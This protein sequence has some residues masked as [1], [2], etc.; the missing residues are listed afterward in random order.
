M[1]IASAGISLRY[2]LSLTPG[3]IAIA[4][5]L[6]GGW[7]TAGCAVYTMIL[8]IGIEHVTHNHK[9][10]DEIED[11][12]VPNII[13]SL[14][15]LFHTLSTFT[16]LYGVYAGVITG[17]FIWIAS[18]STGI[19]GGIEGINSAHELIHRKQIIARLGGIWNLLLVN[20]S[21]FYIEHIKGHH[22]YVGTSRDPATARY[23]ESFYHFFVRTVPAQFLSALNLEAHRLKK[24]HKSP[25]GIRN[26]VVSLFI[27]QIALCFLVYYFLGGLALLAYLHQSVIAFFLLEYVNY[28][29]H[30]G[31]QRKEGQK[32]NAT[33]SWQ[34]DLPI[35]RFALIELSRHSD[36]HITASKPYY[37]LI[38]YDDSPVL[39]AGYFGSFYW[40]LLPKLWF[41]KVNPVLDAYLKR[42]NQTMA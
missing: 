6:S 26:V 29:E 12:T 4:G 25:F 23:G 8:L 19:S 9:K 16:L 39:P 27:A 13:L 40:A 22:R 33:H 37:R 35:S 41:Q 28:I 42:Q 3:L 11:G 31:L 30:Y 38:T 32:V 34:C 36:H 7:W 15:I 2:L 5:N 18:L 20:Y 17:K 24:M 14:H 21:H 10:V 1:K